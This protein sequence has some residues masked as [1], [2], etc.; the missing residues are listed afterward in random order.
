MTTRRL[1]IAVRRG[2][3]T[4]TPPRS[5]GD[6]HELISSCTQPRIAS[7]P[8]SVLIKSFLVPRINSRVKPSRCPGGFTLV[9]LLVVLAIIAILASLLLPGLAK[10]K[11]R[12]KRIS[13]ISNMKQISLG[14]RLWHDD[15]DFRYPWQLDPSEGG[16]QTI[17]EAWKHFATISNEIVT[18]RVLH[19]ASDG[20]KKIAENF[21]AG[22]AGLQTLKN[23]A[24][25]FAVGTESLEV[26]PSM[27]IVTD[28][29]AIGTENGSCTP[30][31]IPGV[32]TILAPAT[33]TRWNRE[34]HV[35]AG[36]MALTDGSAH[37]YTQTALRSHLATAGDP[38]F[39]NCILKP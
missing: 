18:P 10:A 24:I 20:E 38:N 22:S 23:D 9:E 8:Q 11:S 12:G 36:N 14:F 16:T 29:N 27:H 15:N 1:A 25:S 17:T 5:F 31:R 37:Q 33:A 4:A 19:C 3:D 21:S 32:I 34:I 35:Y 6:A 30:A 28:R 2:E 39:S 26:R 7:L 13:C